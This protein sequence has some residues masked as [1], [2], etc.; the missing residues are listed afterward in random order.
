MCLDKFAQKY[1]GKQGEKFF[2]TL[3]RVAL[4]LIESITRSIIWSV[5]RFRFFGT[6]IPG[7]ILY[8]H[9]RGVTYERFP[10]YGFSS[11]VSIRPGIHID[12]RIIPDCSS[13]IMLVQLC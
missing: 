1:S 11:L 10:Q 5:I 13:E 12:I 8:H 4:I 3:S 9:P 7:K 2:V 6:D